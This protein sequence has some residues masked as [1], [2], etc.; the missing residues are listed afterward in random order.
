MLDTPG[1]KPYRI[2]SLFTI[3]KGKRLTK[4]NQT[5]GRTPYIGAV[6]SNNGVTNYVGQPPIH[7]GGTITL[8]YNG[9]VGEAFY[10]EDPFWATDDV[11]VLYPRFNLTRNVALFI[12]TVLRLEKYR[13]AY[14]RK[15]TVDLMND[16]IIY[17]PEKDNKPDWQFME[18]FINEKYEKIEQKTQIRSA[19][20]VFDAT[21]WKQFM[22]SELFECSIA[23]S[24]DYGHVTKGN[25]PFI[26]RSANDNGLQGYVESDKL[27]KGGCITIGMVGTMKAYWQELD[28]AA[29]QNILILRRNGLNKY[30]ALFLTTVLQL[31][32]RDK[33]SYNRPIQKEKFK[34]SFLKLPVD[35]S[36]KPDWQFMEDY[37]KGLPYSDLI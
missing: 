9:S 25:F 20:S 16:S 7:A 26:G 37:I 2:G 24:V 23:R 6:D 19:A 3:K 13:F 36:G 21:N 18:D 8:S 32:M 14:G 29:S 1:W 10:Q 35:S 12:C 30:V 22:I 28:F 5:I 34:S 11:N 4:E 33:Y 27:N 17:L 31:T 15:W